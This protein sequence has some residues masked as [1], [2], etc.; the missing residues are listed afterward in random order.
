MNVNKFTLDLK[1][2]LKQQFKKKHIKKK[3]PTLHLLNSEGTWIRITDRNKIN[4]EYC[5]NT[6][7][8]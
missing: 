4:N 1:L 3:N 6:S 2:H 5:G 8:F 7:K